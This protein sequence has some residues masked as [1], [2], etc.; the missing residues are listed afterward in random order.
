MKVLSV[1][2]GAD[3]AGVSYG[4][5]QAFAASKSV[6]LR[7]AVRLQNWLQ[8]PADLPWERAG[9]AWAA[10]DVVHLHSTLG[11][12]RRFGAD[13]PF[14]LHHHGTKYRNNADLL[15]RAVGENHGRAVVSTHDLL[16]YGDALTWV[17]PMVD[18][19]A[20]ARLRSRQ[21]G[22]LRIG[23]APTRRSTK[24]TDAFLHACSLLDVEVVLI[25]RQ[26]HTDCLKVKGTCDVLYDQVRLGY[27]L[28]AV[29]AWAMGVPVIAGADEA[30]LARMRAEFGELPFVAATEST[31]GDAVRLLT[32]DEVRDEWATRGHEHAVRWHDGRETV[33]RLTPIYH[34]LKEA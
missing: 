15:N 27:G 12:W 1:H 7:S 3:V 19:S 18:V 14:V 6:E 17:P 9:D 8:Y 28:N 32:D 30:T 24:S 34:D 29:E 4:L 21:G 25:E 33:D 23:H 2:R 5:S 11:A 16:A 10:S 20:L 26:R 22:R 13:R 31:I